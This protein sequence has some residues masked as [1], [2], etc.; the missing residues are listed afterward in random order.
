MKFGRNQLT[1][2]FENQQAETILVAILVSIYLTKAILEHGREFNERNPYM[3]FG[4]N[5][6]TNS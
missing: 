4:R 3:K 5:W 6:M 2:D 1:N